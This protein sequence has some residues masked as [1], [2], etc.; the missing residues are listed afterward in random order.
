MKKIFAELFEKFV[1][2]NKREPKGIELIQLKFKANELNRQANKLK[3]VDF[4]KTP[5]KVRPG[6]EATVT[7]LKPKSD[8]VAPG[9]LQADVENLKVDAEDMMNDAIRNKNQA[10]TDLDDFLETGGQPFKKKDDKFLG[11]SMHEEGQIRTG[12]RMFLQDEV[13]NGR[14]KLNKEDLARVMEYF[15]TKADDPILVFK[16]IYGDDAYDAAGKFPGAFEKGDDYNHYREIFKEN[17]G[18][19][20]LKPK[21]ADNLGDGRLVLD[22]ADEVRTPI[23]DEDV[24]FAEGGST[25]TGLN[26]LLGEDDTNSRVPYATGGRRGFLKILAGLGAAGAAFKTGLLS[27]GKGA[28]K[29][30]AKVA[31]E[32]ATSTAPPHFLKLVAKIKALGDD[33]TE[34]AALAERQNVKKYKDFELTEDIA[35]GK[36]EII[37]YKQ[38]DEATYYGQPLTEETYMAYTPGETIIGKGNK[39]VKTL[40]DYEEGTAFVRNDRGY[41][42]EIVEESNTISDDILEEVEAGSGNVPESFYTGPNK[43]KRAEGG[44]MGYAGGK[45]VVEGLVSLLNKK[46]GKDILTTADKIKTPQKTLDREMFKKFETKYPETSAADATLN[47]PVQQEGKFTKA[48]YLIQR[49]ENTIKESPNDKYVQDTFPGFIDELKTNPELAKNENVFKE[50]GGDLPE[51]QQIVVYGDDTLDFFTQKSGPGNIDRIKK[52]MAKHNISREK[53]LKIMKMEPNDQVM[54]LKMLEV[55]N[56]K[57]NSE[58]GRIGLLSGGGVLKKL[59]MNLAKEKGMSGSEVLKVM[60]YKSLPSKIKNLM[61]KEEFDKMKDQRL[62]GV[63]IWKDL[64][65]S[66]QEMT[67]NVDAGLNT[68]AAELF[69]ELEK[70]SPGYGIV[71]RDISDADMLQMEQLIKNIKTKDNRQLNATGGL[72]NLLGE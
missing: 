6:Q 65:Y 51:G 64:M 71:P 1:K 72:A 31:A 32:A 44:R 20:Y 14:L 56:R 18:E 35:T 33:V 4:E 2:S 8:D 42:G 47:I 17:M 10:M 61:T 16:K 54:E 9:T 21:N 38:S 24:P 57:L 70:T 22:S 5:V 40:D 53:A 12:V 43:I 7:T 3:V 36:Q 37:R 58:G 39:P 34:T 26:Y 30:A 62:E 60:N 68:P 69:K 67:K 19:V 25:S 11:G 52:L 13:K 27:L 49:L 59:I 29:P 28:A 48:E 15:P 23:K 45:K 63:E 41:T 55:A 66:Q 46:A 50:L